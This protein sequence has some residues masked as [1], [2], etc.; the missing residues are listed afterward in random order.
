MGYPTKIATCCYCGTRA[1]LVL[2][3]GRHELTCS[4]CGAPLH[5]MKRLKKEPVPQET[6]SYAQER[7][8]S[9]KKA[10]KTRYD[11]PHRRARKKRK[12]M[13]RHL[14]EEAFDVLEDIFD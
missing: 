1:A 12:G 14:L 5:D 4:K 10:Y 8:K 11:A 6:H 2:E 3:K 7:R 13:M 9:G